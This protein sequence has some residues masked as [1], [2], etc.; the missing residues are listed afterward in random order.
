MRLIRTNPILLF[1]VDASQESVPL[2]ASLEIH[3]ML[4]ACLEETVIRNVNT[5]VTDKDLKNKNTRKS[6]LLKNFLDEVLRLTRMPSRRM[7]GNL[8]QA[9]QVLANRPNAKDLPAF[10]GL[11]P[12]LLSAFASHSVMVS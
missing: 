10:V 12:Q 3:Q 8:I 1:A 9:W 6:E 5:I 2:A 7:A 11:V 4:S